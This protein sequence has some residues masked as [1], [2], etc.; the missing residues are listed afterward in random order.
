MVKV[1]LVILLTKVI[2]TGSPL[3]PSAAEQG[4]LPSAIVLHKDRMTAMRMIDRGSFEEI[5]HCPAAH[6]LL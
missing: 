3:F 5:L 6:S 4:L 1:A 2:D